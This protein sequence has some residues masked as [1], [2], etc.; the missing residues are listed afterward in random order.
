MVRELP[1][2][3]LWGAGHGRKI[4][5]SG[6]TE[7]G[8]S[9]ASIRASSRGCAMNEMG[10]TEHVKRCELRE[11][12]TQTLIS[13]ARSGDERARNTLV[14][15]YRPRLVRWVHGRVPIRARN[16]LDTD[17]I[18]QNSLLRALAPMDRFEPR[19]E[20]A[21]LGYLCRIALNQ[22]RDEARRLNRRPERVELEEHHEDAG[23]S[24]LDRA[25]GSD[26]VRR[27]DEALRRL[28]EDYAV[29]IR[30]RFELQYSY[31]EIAAATE[32]PTENAVRLLLQR[33][34][35]RLVR[36][37]HARGTRPGS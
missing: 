30:L 13:R 11:L 37:M 26:E 18:V 9:P 6:S 8:F 28:P 2:Y 16:V 7:L 34:M 32:R 25:I 35:K 14:E 21:F 29:V 27:Y 12:G 3:P 10:A 24:P 23:P 31:A 19:H 22:I 17:D 5:V 1:K 4:G 15:R 36:E 33:A 20:G